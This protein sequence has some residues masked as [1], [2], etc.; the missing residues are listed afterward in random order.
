MEQ[1]QLGNKPYMLK[2]GDG[3]VYRSGI[4]MIVKASEIRLGSGAAVLEYT[5]LHGEEPRRAYPPN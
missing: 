5:S 4:D 3:W 1:A 2:A